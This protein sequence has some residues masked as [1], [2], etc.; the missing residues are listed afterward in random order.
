[1][2]LHAA[3]SL[4][5][6]VFGRSRWDASAIEELEACG[7][8]AAIP[9]L[10]PVL[11]TGTRNDVPRAARA[12]ETLLSRTSVED[13]PSLD[14]SVRRGWYG[15]EWRRLEPG[16]LTKWVGPGEPGTSLLRLWSFHAN[17]F[18]RQEAVRRLA[19]VRDGSELPY[20]LIRLND[21]VRQ[22][23]H[24]AHGALVDR[25]TPEYAGWFVKSLALVVRL[26][27]ARRADHGEILE[28][29]ARLLAGPEAR[30]PMLAV[31]RSASKE[32]RRASFR[33]LTAN[34]PDELPALLPAALDV[35]DPM[36]RL[37]ATRALAGALDRAQLRAAVDALARDASPWVRREAL[38]I[39][40]AAFP[41]EATEPLTRALLD[42]SAVVR[43]DARFH[44]AKSAEVDVAQLYRDATATTRTSVLVAALSGLAETGTAA[45]APTLEAYLAH[46]RASVRKT[47]V[48][49]LVRLGGEQHLDTVMERVFDPSPAVSTQACKVVQPHATRVGASRLWMLLEPPAATHVRRNLLRVL[50]AL[51]K[52]ERIVGLLRAACDMDGAVATM[53]RDY[54]VDWNERYNRNQST[55]TRERLA[56]VEEALSRA[57]SRLPADTVA[58]IRFA[59]RAFPRG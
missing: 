2:R 34:R 7:E 39:L 53:A 17:G 5:A 24:V 46:P 55:P 33:L 26:Q 52:W 20:L 40:V 58:S 16:E 30:A 18:V 31:M 9:H 1:V 36:I 14:E 3:P 12:V 35:P 48:R 41:A 8:P 49:Y 57:E 11:I 43:A 25:L 45:D 21:W 56:E 29:I 6:R 38:R 37:W 32:V 13:L 54:V 23:R 44:L 22:V 15:E 19:L 50:G 27:E 10:A 28:E 59:I 47:A 4:A 51:P 42:P